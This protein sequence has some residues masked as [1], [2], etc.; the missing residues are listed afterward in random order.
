MCA[1]LCACVRVCVRARRG[2]HAQQHLLVSLQ[3]LYKCAFMKECLQPFLGVVVTELFEGGPPLLLCQPGVLE[4]GSVDDQQRT[5]RVLTGL[6]SSEE[7]E[8]TGYTLVLKIRM[9]PR[10]LFLSCYYHK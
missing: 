9:T 6:Q 5:E 7:Q 3:L 8:N 1:C 4:T 10:I 2:L